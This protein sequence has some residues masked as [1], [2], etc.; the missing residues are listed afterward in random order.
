[1]SG[2][3]E[4]EKGEKR[5][6][7]RILKKN[8][9]RGLGSRLRGGRTRE[10]GKKG[11]N[12]S[13]KSPRAL[14][15]WDLGAAPGFGGSRVCL[16]SFA[17]RFSLPAL[18]E[19]QIPRGP[20]AP[21]PAGSRGKRRGGDAVLG[22]KRGFWGRFFFGKKELWGHLFLGKKA[23]WGRFF[24]GQTESGD[25]RRLFRGKT[26]YGDDFLGEKAKVVSW[27]RFFRGKRESGFLGTLF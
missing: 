7:G 4:R 14:Q 16:P 18:G 13:K 2:C 10:N 12:P 15:S 23:M 20:E 8:P 19:S 3:S 11:G 24:R 25:V 17:S 26:R 22:G 9:G 21:G 1:M 27:G 6:K 5:G